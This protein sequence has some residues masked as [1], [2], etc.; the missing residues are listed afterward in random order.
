MIITENLKLVYPD[1]IKTK[2]I[3]EGLNL[4]INDGDRVALIGP[5]GSG[6]SSLIY[7]LSLLKMP[8]A[9]KIYFDGKTC[10]NTADRINMRYDSFGFI[11][12]QHFLLGY[13]TVLENV[14]IAV[15]NADSKV[16]DRAREILSSL[17]LGEHTHKKP[18][19]LS[20]GERQRVAIA[21]ALIKNPSVIFADE[22]TAS[23]DH[24]TGAAVMDMLKKAAAGKILITATHDIGLLDGGERVLR[25]AN[26]SI[27]E[28]PAAIP[29]KA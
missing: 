15:K 28:N 23:L 2:T 1:G 20:G 9:G 16:Y 7:L 12:Q 5:S 22:P 17:G 18:Y 27:N 24:D 21:R 26:G 25:V 13:L 4:T 10:E 29:V 14:A 19:Q 8:T 6:K 11:F 3:F